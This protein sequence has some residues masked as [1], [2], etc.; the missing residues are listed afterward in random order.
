[1]AL[2]Y[3]GISVKYVVDEYVTTQYEVLKLPEWNLASR[4]WRSLIC[5]Q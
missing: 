5:K 1:M 3:R 2:Y 4:W